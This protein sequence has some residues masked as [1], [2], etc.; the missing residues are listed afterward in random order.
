MTDMKLVDSLEN[1]TL[2][3]NGGVE[4]QPTTGVRNICGVMTIPVDWVGGQQI[5]VV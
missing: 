4:K 5:L 2:P 3:S 1:G